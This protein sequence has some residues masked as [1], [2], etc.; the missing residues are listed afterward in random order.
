MKIKLIPENEAER[1]L[2][3][4]FE[5]DRVQDAFVFGNYTDEN[6]ELKDFHFWKGN[7]RYLIG[8]LDFFY[9]EINDERRAKNEK[10]A[11]DAKKFEMVSQK[12]SGFKKKGVC[13]GKAEIIDV[14]DIVVPPP[15][16]DL[17][18]GNNH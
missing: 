12:E 4:N 13:S 6:G 9:N 1:K 8:S 17:L 3:A 18:D 7:Y 14:E 10:K 5:Y 15:G 11:E 16:F 2:L